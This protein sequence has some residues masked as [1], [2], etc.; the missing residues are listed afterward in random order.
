MAHDKMLRFV[1]VSP[2]HCPKTP[3][4]LPRADFGS[5]L[6]RVR[7]QKGKPRQAGSSFR[8]VACRTAFAIARLHKQNPR[9]G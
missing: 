7:R 1:D 2:G 9:T 8:T 4:D 6:R 3:P 5:I